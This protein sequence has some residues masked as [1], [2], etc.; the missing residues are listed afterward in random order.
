MRIV[1]ENPHES[2]IKELHSFVLISPRITRPVLSF[3]PMYMALIVLDNFHRNLI[4]EFIRTYFFMFCAYLGKYTIKINEVLLS[5]NWI[6]LYPHKTN[7][8]EIVRCSL[9]SAS[10]QNH[11]DTTVPSRLFSVLKKSEEIKQ[12]FRHTGSTF[13]HQE[14]NSCFTPTSIKTKISRTL[15]FNTFIWWKDSQAY[16]TRYAYSFI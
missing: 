2:F 6:L 12:N 9:L 4:C 3:K 7:C 11:L 5:F 14:I 8:P 10:K 15:I 1:S 16:V 13:F